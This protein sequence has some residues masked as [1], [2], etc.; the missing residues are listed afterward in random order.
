MEINDILNQIIMAAFNEAK[1]R[2]HE[3]LT[4]EHLLYS[5]LFFK[6]GEQII[7][8]CGIDIERLKRR[9]EGFLKDNVPIISSGDPEQSVGFQNIMARA[10]WHTTTAEKDEL[11]IGD[12]FIAILDEKESYASYFLKVEGLERLDLLDYISHG[13]S[14][15]PEDKR[16]LEKELEDDSKHRESKRRSAL[17]MFTTELTQKAMDGEMEPL[18]GR[19][20]VLERTLQ[21]LCRRF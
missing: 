2:N 6:E 15:L 8:G 21:V 20:D 9:I 10:I 7:K 19:E 14:V 13:V 12:V 17:E 5:S 3:Y 11:D 4:P 18:I 16:S 1:L